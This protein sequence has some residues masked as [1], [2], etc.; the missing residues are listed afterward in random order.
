MSLKTFGNCYVELDVGVVVV[1]FFLG[2]FKNSGFFL[3]FTPTAFKLCTS[4]I[5]RKFGEVF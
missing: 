4:A 2:G 3:L 1:G 5:F